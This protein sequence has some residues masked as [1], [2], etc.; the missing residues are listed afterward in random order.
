MSILI[1]PPCAVAM[2]AWERAHT[3]SQLSKVKHS[4][5]QWQAKAKQRSDHNRYLRKQLARVKAERDQAKQDLKETQTRLRQLESQAQAV[6]VRPKVD[7][8]WLSLHLFLEARMSFRAVC[9]VLSLLASALGIKRAPCVQTV[10]NWVIRLSIVRIESARG[11]RGLPLAHAP[12]SNGLIW[13][14]DLS[15]GLGSGKIVAV[16]AIDAH[17]HQLLGAAPSLS[18]VR[19]IGVSVAESWT[20]EA[21]ADLLDRLI[22]QMG[23]PAAYLKDGGSDLHKATDLLAARGLGSPCI[24]DIS[25]AAAGMLKHDYQHHPAFEQF[26]SACGCVSGKLK[27]TI[28][29]CLAPPTV[30]TK[31]RFMHVHRLVTWAD[32]LLKL[33]PAGRAK[34]GSIFARLRVCFD[35]LP[36][37][38]DL[39]KRF[40]ADAQG[41]LECQKILKT[42]GLSHG[43]LAQCKPLI[44]EMPSVLL[45]LEF[46]AYLEYQLATAKTLGLDHIG[47]PIS[48]DAI[49]SLFG[50]AKRHG[51]G[52]TQ[53]AA[54]MA[55]RLPALCGA[56]TREE[57]E[58]VLGIS[59]ARQ[60]KIMGQCISLTKQRREVL[61]HR[62]ELES[63][64]RSQG[65]AHVELLPSPKNRSNHAAIVNLATGCADQQGPHLVPQ[66][67]SCIIE[68]VGPPDMREAALT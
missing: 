4:R 65:E 12:F 47:L 46:E 34:D 42:K 25:H 11:L 43:T 23:R 48:S 41:L 38:K 37:C 7:V 32:R 54:R 68:N 27:Q 67:T 18:H 1:Y 58:Q 60:H 45:R 53:D 59:V 56:P 21:I 3:M 5:N 6:A 33:S 10:I 36:A 30:R 52:Q 57:A 19:C 51:V 15:I 44:S 55:L 13:M 22:A 62:K 40:R 63:L 28:L 8:V 31:A 66:Q 17:H 2:G 26:L 16:L 64:G 49:E 61:G 14:I 24:D 20:G 9:R 39:I 35:K 50:V 29:A